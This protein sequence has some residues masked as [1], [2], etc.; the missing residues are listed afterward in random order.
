LG[1]QYGQINA[2]GKQ[3]YY[4]EVKQQVGNPFEIA[5]ERNYQQEVI[6][7]NQLQVELAKRMI[8]RDASVA[9]HE[10]Q[11]ESRK[12]N[13]LDTFKSAVSTMIEKADKRREVGDVGELEYNVLVGISMELDVQYQQQIALK[14]QAE[15]ALVRLTSKQL[16]GDASGAYPLQEMESIEEVRVAPLFGSLAEQ[17]SEVALSGVK[18]ASKAY[19]PSLSLGY[20]NQQIEGARGLDGVM[21]GVSIPLWNA[22]QKSVVQQQKIEVEIIEDRTQQWL[23]TSEQDLKVEYARWQALDSA[24]AGYRDR[25]LDGARTVFQQSFHAYELG[26]LNYLEFLQLAKAGIQIE[27]NYWNLRLEHAKAF[28]HITYYL[29]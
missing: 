15:N 21:A 17:E 26:E 4:F 10:W 27:M 23:I 3:D 1:V 12:L 9:W 18:R 25:T 7:R 19:Y 22:P 8:S 20:F 29:P 14:L 16:N 13:R 2:P 11:I 5:G 6:Q 28:E 24:L